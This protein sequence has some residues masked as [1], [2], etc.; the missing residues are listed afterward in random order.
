V[1]TLNELECNRLILQSGDKV[2]GLSHQQMLANCVETLKRAGELAVK[3]KIEIL[4]ENIDPEENQ[5]YF[6]TSS[7]EGFEIIRKV[8]NSRIK[9]LYDFFHEQIAEG[10]LIAKLEKNLDVIGLLHV[11]DVPGRHEPGTG[12]INYPV[13]FR[14]LGELGYNGFVAMEFMPIGDAVPALRAARELALSSGRTNKQSPLSQANSRR[15]Y[16]TS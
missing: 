8:G 16:V 9:F 4:V 3:H 5:N 6:I 11:A 12:E 15:S 7:S 10:N 13:I 1:P 14:K 2:P